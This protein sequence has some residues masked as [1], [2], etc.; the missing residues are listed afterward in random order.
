MTIFMC[1]LSV[2]LGLLFLIPSQALAASSCDQLDI[3]LSTSQTFEIPIRNGQFCAEVSIFSP[4]SLSIQGTGNIVSPE[5]GTWTITAADNGREVS[6]QPSNSNITSQDEITWNTQ[7]NWFN[8]NIKLDASW[9]NQED[10]TL[11]IQLN[12]NL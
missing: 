2:I 5:Q 12:A 3:Q 4:L 11:I 1:I 8:N 7:A 9:S 10:T 6:F